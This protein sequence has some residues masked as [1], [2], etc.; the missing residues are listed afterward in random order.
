MTSTTRSPE[1]IYISDP[2]CSW[3]WGFVPSLRAIREK[4]PSKFQYRFIVGGLR[5]G[6]A[7]QPLD[8][9]LR[10][11]LLNSWQEVERR[12]GQ[13]FNYSFFERKDFLYDT[14]PACRAIVT[15]RHL[16]PES[17]FNYNEALQSAF[18][19]S[20]L[21]PTNIETFLKVACEIGLEKTAFRESFLS[22]DMAQQTEGDFKEAR[23]LGVHGFPSI[24]VRTDSNTT[25]VT[26]GWLPL[27]ALTTQL[28]PWLQ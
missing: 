26:R 5:T 7:T 27:K 8:E 24:V 23:I 25:V 14:E 9:N 28:L 4:Y 17:A 15:S 11:H 21:D 3:C 16:S 18:Y 22:S 20:G 2:L 12:S 1:L 19:R 10:S 6:T 13:P